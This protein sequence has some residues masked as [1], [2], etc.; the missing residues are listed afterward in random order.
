MHT[1]FRVASVVA[2]ALLAATGAARAQQADSVA[3]QGA[4]PG[5]GGLGGQIGGS[6]MYAEGDYAEGAQ[7]RLSFTGHFRYVINRRWGWQVSPS[8]TW[9]GY[10]S[11]AD[12]PFVDSNFPGDGLSK[13]HYLSQVLGVSSQLQWYSGSGRQRWHIG[14]G[15]AIYRVVVQNRRKVVEDP[16]SRELHRGMHMGAVAE[17]GYERFLK[18]LPNTS[19]EFTVGCQT[20]FAK[21]DNRWASGWN[22]NPAVVDARFGAHYYYEFRKPKPKSTKPGLGN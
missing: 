4:L 12:A 18:R 20:A 22:G 14:I 1:R 2:L 7:P 16:V 15:P 13:E 8:F 9:N 10:V 5:R 3:T 21:S 17:I 11:H 6:Y 19:L